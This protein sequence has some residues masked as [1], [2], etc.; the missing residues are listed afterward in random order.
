MRELTPAVGLAGAQPVSLDRTTFRQ[1]LATE[2]YTVSWKAD[3]TRY[4][5]G[6]LAVP[7]QQTAVYMADRN[8]RVYRTNVHVPDRKLLAG[9]AK[10]AAATRT[11]LPAVPMVCRAPHR[12][13]KRAAYPM[14]DV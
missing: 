14:A 10:H 13:K 9:P 8:F 4:L 1:R 7:P 2:P 6:I 5:L 3:G 11:P 12:Q